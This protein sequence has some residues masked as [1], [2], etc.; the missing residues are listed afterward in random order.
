MNSGIWTKNEQKIY[1]Q[2]ILHIINKKISIQEL[3]LIMKT[4][5]ISQIKSHHQKSY[6]KI[7]K[8]SLILLQIKYNK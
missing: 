5:N 7:K 2:Y 6:N 4:R 3:S 1:T 8:I